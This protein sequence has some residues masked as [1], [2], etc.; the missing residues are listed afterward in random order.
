MTTDKTATREEWLAARVALL[1]VETDFMLCD[2]GRIQ[3]VG[4]PPGQP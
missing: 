3:R 1:E 2:R 4:R